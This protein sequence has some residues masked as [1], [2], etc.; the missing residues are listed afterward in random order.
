MTTA[1]KEASDRSG[2]RGQRGSA[3][4]FARALRSEFKRLVSQKWFYWCLAGMLLVPSLMEWF[5][6]F[7]NR[8]IFE[9]EIVTNSIGPNALLSGVRQPGSLFMWLIIV[10]SVTNDY[11]SGH[12]KLVASYFPSRWTAPV[13]KWVVVT[14]IAS[15][16][17]FL[18]FLLSAGVYWLTV[19]GELQSTEDLAHAA[20][21]MAK[22][23]L[24]YVPLTSVLMMGIAH[25]VRGSVPSIIIGLGWPMV[26]AIVPLS[27]DSLKRVA[28][29]APFNN[30]RKWTW[31]TEG[32]F[33]EDSSELFANG[34]LWP[35]LYYAF[36]ALVIGGVSLYALKKRPA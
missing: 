21:T 31:G 36:I 10:L 20:K 15:A 1:V 11:S 29:F 24:V 26:A 2:L 7:T 35:I 5:V 34:G 28:P 33:T 16:G 22:A 8:A 18:A 6:A 13:A 25:L 19:P 23:C 9:A 17:L 32:L 12:S 14:L 27:L 3:A 4:S 30:A